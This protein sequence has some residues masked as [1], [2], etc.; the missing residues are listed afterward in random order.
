MV[1]RRSLAGAPTGED[2]E[3]LRDWLRTLPGSP[4][5]HEVAVLAC[6]GAHRDDA[7]RPVWAYVEADASAGLAR[8]RCLAC[9]TSVSLL[10]SAERWTHPPMHACG[11]CSGSIVEVAAGLHLPD[12]EHVSWV[13]VGVRCVDCGRLTG[14]TDMLLDPTPVADVLSRL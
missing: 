2:V 3:D 8:R 13:V 11:G 1:V 10:D 7:E 14:V 12:G 4:A 6:G 9:G 5:V